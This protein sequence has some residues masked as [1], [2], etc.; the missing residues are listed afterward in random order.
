MADTPQ[1]YAPECNKEGLGKFDFCTLTPTQADCIAQKL[2]LPPVGDGP[3]PRETLN[4]GLIS[5]DAGNAIQVRPDGGLYVPQP[6]TGGL[7]FNHLWGGHF[8]LCQESGA[9]SSRSYRRAMLDGTSGACLDGN[10]DVT[11]SHAKGF[12][13]PDAILIRR[14]IPSISNS[15]FI[16]C[17]VLSPKQTAPLRGK[18]CLFSVYP[19]AGAQWTAPSRQFAIAAICHRVQSQ[20]IVRLD[21][22]FTGDNIII[23]SR[24]AVADYTPKAFLDPITMTVDVPA[25]ATQVAIRIEVPFNGGTN[26][27]DLLL[28][29]AAMLSIGTQYVPMRPLTYD[30][31]ILKG[32]S[33]YQSNRPYSAPSGSKTR[34]GSVGGQAVRTATTKAVIINHTLGVPMDPSPSVFIMSTEVDDDN[35]TL[36]NLTTGLDVNALLYD[37]SERG[38]KATN[39][40][41]VS[42]G[43]EVMA[44][45]VMRKMY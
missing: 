42:D 18:T 34:A 26:S 38:F 25:D 24:T 20:S 39:V 2:I 23:N 44:N 29:E 31:L 11:V 36:F 16:L 3:N 4:D 6:E 40:N 12:H 28:L 19:T 32:M 17:I 27:E 30:E 10:L 13:Y 43:D 5:D 37:I 14:T 1:L 21:G 22:Y 35:N 15:P 8:A 7:D 33:R 45:Y 9:Y 41:N